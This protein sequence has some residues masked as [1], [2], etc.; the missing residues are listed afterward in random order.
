[1]PNG[2]GFKN[3]ADEKT[4]PDP[5]GERGN[6]GSRNGFLHPF[7]ED[8]KV[9][10]VK[11]SAYQDFTGGISD[12]FA[13]KDVNLDALQ[14][15]GKKGQMIQEWNA[16]HR[17]KMTTRGWGGTVYNSNPIPEVYEPATSNGVPDANAVQYDTVKK[18]RNA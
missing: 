4:Q 5:A 7:N 14:A 3:H 2:K 17:D 6:E 13:E 15:R 18:D 12:N 11:N 1:M 10:N 16:T 8:Q 9:T